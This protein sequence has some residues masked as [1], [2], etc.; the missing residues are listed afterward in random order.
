MMPLSIAVYFHYTCMHVQKQLNDCT[1]IHKVGTHG[2]RCLY[3]RTSGRNT[4]TLMAVHMYKW[5]GLMYTS[6]CK[7]VHRAGTTG[8][9]YPRKCTRGRNTWT[10]GYVD[11]HNRNYGHPQWVLWRTT[12]AVVREYEGYVRNLPEVRNLRED[13]KGYLI[14]MEDLL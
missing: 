1:S 11:N 7:G 13:S 4:P 14:K 9:G 3:M 10:E 8:H 6:V 2:H 12:R 5:L